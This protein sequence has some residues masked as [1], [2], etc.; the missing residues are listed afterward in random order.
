MIT[1]R[2]AFM[3]KTEKKLGKIIKKNRGKVTFRKW[4]TEKQ[5]QMKNGKKE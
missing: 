2:L 4:R 5:L 3:V 1:F